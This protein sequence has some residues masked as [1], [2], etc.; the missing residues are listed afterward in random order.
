[1]L[2]F[3]RKMP[4]IEEKKKIF[5]NIR[6]R[7][8]KKYFQIFRKLKIIG[9]IDDEAA[10][11]SRVMIVRLKIFVPYLRLGNSFQ[12]S[13]QDFFSCL[14]FRR[15]NLHYSVFSNDIFAHYWDRNITFFSSFSILVICVVEYVWF[16]RQFYS[17]L[18]LRRSAPKISRISLLKFSPFVIIISEKKLP[19]W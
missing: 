4:E 17:C 18:L 15:Q 19:A 5:K 6:F 2:H 7:V 9:K 14:Y 12:V 10:L 13:G 1:M 16:I 8:Y 3:L 11:R